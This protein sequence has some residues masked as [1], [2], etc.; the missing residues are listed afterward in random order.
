M[1]CM[2]PVNVSPYPVPTICPHCG[3]DRAELMPKVGDYSRY[4]CPTCQDFSVSGTTERLFE[5]GTADPKTARIII[6]E[7]GQRWLK[8]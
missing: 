6:T 1:T 8:P 2:A 3:N 7:D 4:R 5:L